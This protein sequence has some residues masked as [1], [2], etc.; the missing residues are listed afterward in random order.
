MGTDSVAIVGANLAGGHVA[1]ALRNEGFGG[2]ILL[3][4]AEPHRPYDRP[5]V[6]KELLTGAK[7]AE[8]TFLHPQPWYQDH[9]IELLLGETVD[10]IETARPSVTLRSGPRI[11]VDRIVLC[12]GGRARRLDIPGGDL[13]GIHYLRTLDDAAAL[14]ADLA[15][16]RRVVVVGS[17]FIGA[18]AAASAR[19]MGHDVTI[20]EFDPRPFT[21]VLGSEVG[22]LVERLHSV[23]GVIIRGGV[24]VA[25]FVGTERVEAV[26]GADGERFEADVVI[27]GIGMEPATELAS[28]AHLTVANGVWVNEFCESSHPS[29]LVAG[30]VANQHNP[31]VGE[32]I[33]LEHWQNALHQ[34]GT[35]ARTIVDL[36]EP[37]VA[38]PWYWSNQFDLEL[39]I[40][41]HSAPNDEV[42]FRGEPESGSFSALHLREGR[43][44][45]AISA[46]RP[47]ELRAALRL[48]ERRATV[49]ATVLRDDDRDLSDALTA[50]M[51]P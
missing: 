50:P 43:I 46:N 42:V 24:N 38:V 16:P 1:A 5:P 25:R 2:R 22:A 12:T 6:S 41:G 15:Q 11:A 48:I 31:F 8:D 17:G 36:R 21:R 27:V 30:D 18:E 39:Q 47:R 34:A 45:A 19:C 37:N 33:R 14:R 13:A 51:T 26:E 3:I 29:V 35:V 4:G 20:V 49:D 9:E 10:S 23:N 32:R 40:A 44:V 7:S 28:Q